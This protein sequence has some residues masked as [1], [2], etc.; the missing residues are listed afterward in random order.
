M[1]KFK[2]VYIP[3]FKRES[4]KKIVLND[5]FFKQQYK[6]KKQKSFGKVKIVY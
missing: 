3:I 6:F 5:L 4:L 2:H 1:F